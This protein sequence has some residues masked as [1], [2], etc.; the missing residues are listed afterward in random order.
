MP[1]TDVG[2]AAMLGGPGLRAAV[3]YVSLHSG[4][5]TEDNE[6]PEGVYRR[7][8]IDLRPP[9]G[10]EIRS[11]DPMPIEVPEGALVGSVGFW[12][13]PTGGQMLAWE[14]VPPHKFSGRGIYEIGAAVFELLNVKR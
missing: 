12:T 4:P 14:P 5:P 8:P 2:L 10:A 13:A 11:N 1:Y 3:R 9:S 6:L 7:K